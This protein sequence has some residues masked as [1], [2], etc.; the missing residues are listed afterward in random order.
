MRWRAAKS[1]RGKL[2]GSNRCAFHR[3]PAATGPGSLSRRILYLRSRR[4]ISS[5]RGRP[6]P[7]TRGLCCNG[8]WNPVVKPSYDDDVCFFKGAD[9]GFVMWAHRARENDRS[10]W[11]LPLFSFRPGYALFRAFNEGKIVKFSNVL[12]R[13]NT[14]ARAVNFIVG[15]VN[16]SEEAN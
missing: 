11:E 3:Y 15:N 10:R 7:T 6:E 1:S 4:F 14:V 8:S 12:G 16:F 5:S 13:E 9:E 2:E